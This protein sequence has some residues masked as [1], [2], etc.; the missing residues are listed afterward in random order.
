MNRVISISILI[1]TFVFVACEDSST[2]GADPVDFRSYYP[3]ALGNQWVYQTKYNDMPKDTITSIV[4]KYQIINGRV[5]FSIK[6]SSGSKS[7]YNWDGNQLY[8]TDRLSDRVLLFKGMKKGDT[9]Y[10]SHEDRDGFSEQTDYVVEGIDETLECCSK[11][12]SKV[13]KIKQY[14]KRIYPQE[15]EEYVRYLYYAKDIGLLGSD[16]VKD[17]DTTES[18]LMSYKLVE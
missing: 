4:E 3:S 18:K 16:F 6:H 9:L 17:G 15:T 10:A 1:F 13:I 11:M 5:K 7:Y 12:Y 2:G 14:N 8:Y